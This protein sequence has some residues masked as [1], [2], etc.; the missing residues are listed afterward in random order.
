MEGDR[1]EKLNFVGEECKPG[2]D[3]AE[4]HGGPFTV[5]EYRYAPGSEFPEHQHDSAQLTTIIS[6]EIVFLLDGREHRLGTGETFFI[7][8][9]VPH[10]AFV[11]A[12]S[13]EVVSVNVFHPRRKEHP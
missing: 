8:G 4:W 13:P 7:P 9:G 5:I 12:D 3:R 11:P 1:P 6:G 10:G 2:V